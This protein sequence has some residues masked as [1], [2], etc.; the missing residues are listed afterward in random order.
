MNTIPVTN[1]RQLITGF[2]IRAARA[3]PI[4][5]LAFPLG[6]KHED[7]SIEVVAFYYPKDWREH[8]A[9][10]QVE[11]PGKWWLEALEVAAA[12]KMMPLGT[13]HSHCYR[14]GETV[15]DEVQSLGDLDSWDIIDRIAGICN[16]IELASGKKQCGDP[17]F[18][19]PPNNC[20]V[21]IK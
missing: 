15:F 4:E 19:G 14:R 12:G 16:V 18:H 21:T 3:W 6:R 17:V 5:F 20:E 8:A 10:K 7:G 11:L 9:E 1:A 2:K 13:L